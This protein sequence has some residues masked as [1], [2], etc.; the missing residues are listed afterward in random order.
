MSNGLNIL[1]ELKKAVDNANQCHESEIHFSDYEAWDDNTNVEL[2]P[3]MVY[4]ARQD[5]VDYVRQMNLYTKVSIDECVK[6]TGKKPIAV[7]WIDV[8]KQDKNNPLYRSRLVGKEFNTHND[9][10]L[11]AATPPL[12]ALRLILSICLLYTS[13]SPRDRQKSRMPSSA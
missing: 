2:D 11:Y 10:S 12:E 5:E 9:M 8:N 4:K 7:R 1:A 6:K 13:P 3:K